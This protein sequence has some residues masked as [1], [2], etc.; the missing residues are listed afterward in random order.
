M[1][2]HDCLF[3]SLVVEGL[4]EIK[5]VEIIRLKSDNCATQY[6]SKYVLGMWHLLLST[7]GKVIITYYGASGHGKGLVD[8]M[9]GFGVKGPLK[10]AVMTESFH[11]RCAEDIYNLL[12]KKTDDKK[13][14]YF[15]TETEIE[16]QKLKKTSLPIKGSGQMHMIS[17]FPD[18][19]VQSKVNLCSCVKC[20][21]GL[22]VNCVTGEK[23]RVEYSGLSAEDDSGICDSDCDENDFG[24]DDCEEDDLDDMEV[25]ELHSNSVLDIVEKGDIIALF[26][27][28][29]SIELFYLLKVTEVTKESDEDVTE[30]LNLHNGLHCIK[31]GDG[32]IKGRYLEKSMEKKTHIEYKLSKSESEVYVLPTQVMYPG[33]AMG[34]D[35]CLPI[36][37]WGRR[38]KR[39]EISYSLFLY[40]NT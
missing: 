38:K 20:S 22:F 4:V 21:S 29:Q 32:Y 28:P 10:R 40:I 17:Y 24:E 12:L 39:E 36:T 18:G 30:C 16:A 15:V 33:V 34:E 2:K 35:L 11:Y 31:K 37:V 26:S 9:S 3:T 8:A 5:P 1:K 23:G 7:L 13:L 19:T 14:Y 25:Y 27:P 6:K